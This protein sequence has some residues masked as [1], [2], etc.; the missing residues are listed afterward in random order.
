[1]ILTTYNNGNSKN[2]KPIRDTDNKSSKF[3]TRKWYAINDLNNT[4]YC[5]GNENGATVKFETK[6]ISRNI[7]EVIKT[8]LSYFVFFLQ[9][10]IAYTKTLTSN[11]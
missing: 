8:I 10:D 3:A 9:K 4:G 5:E 2:R 1:M 7:N 11:N 6:V